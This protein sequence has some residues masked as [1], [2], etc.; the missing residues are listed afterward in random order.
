[1]RVVAEPTAVDVVQWSKAPVV[2]VADAVV[3]VADD[4]VGRLGL[5]MEPVRA[6]LATDAFR[7]GR[8]RSLP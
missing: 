4:T 8:G 1:M 6:V 2:A 7:A 5:E 3:L